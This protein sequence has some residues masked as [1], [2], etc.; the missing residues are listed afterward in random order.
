MGSA[1]GQGLPWCS[2]HLSWIGL[3]K[4]HTEAL[5][6]HELAHVF[7]A[8]TD[9]LS[10]LSLPEIFTD[11][12]VQTLASGLGWAVDNVREKVTYLHD[13]NEQDANTIAKRWGYNAPAMRRWVSRHF[14]REDFLPLVY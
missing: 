6:A 9:T 10:M 7:Q 2:S 14:R 12:V 11:E 4:K 8:S 13:P 5:I 1:K 3:P